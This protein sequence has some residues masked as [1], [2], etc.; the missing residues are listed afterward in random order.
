M[1][2]SKLLDLKNAGAFEKLDQQFTGAMDLGHRATLEL[3]KAIPKDS[4]SR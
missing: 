4:F 1:A 2:G 3:L